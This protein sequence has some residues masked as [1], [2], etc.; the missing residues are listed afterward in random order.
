MKD[1]YIALYHL[2]K[3]ANG[4]FSVLGS[5]ERNEVY[6]SHKPRKNS[7]HDELQVFIRKDMGI[8]K[9]ILSIDIKNIFI[10]E[11]CKI[12]LILKDVKII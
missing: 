6:L 12:P 4:G 5:L 3:R 11:D 2:H 1:K 7:L 8:S 9:Q 10:D